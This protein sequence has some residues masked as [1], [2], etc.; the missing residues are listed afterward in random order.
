M[1]R[2]YQSSTKAYCIKRRI[3]NL[4]RLLG[5]DLGVRNGPVIVIST[6]LLAV[7][8]AVVVCGLMW[9]PPAQDFTPDEKARLIGNS[10]DDIYSQYAKEFGR[11]PSDPRS[12]F[13]ELGLDRDVALINPWTGRDIRVRRL[14]DHL[15]TGDYLLVPATMKRLT[16]EWV[17]DKRV[18]EKSQT[19]EGYWLWLIGPDPLTPEEGLR[20][21]LDADWEYLQ[22]VGLKNVVTY[23]SPDDAHSGGWERIE[24]E[25]LIPALKRAISTKQPQP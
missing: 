10:L 17:N 13:M 24:M 20:E 2:H 23:W 16:F 18:N 22:Q 3:A 15:G 4:N 19:L 1:R 11:L 25:P 8:T 7:V 12:A 14:G 9:G 5:Y 21:F 6:V